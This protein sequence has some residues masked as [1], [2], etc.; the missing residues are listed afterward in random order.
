MGMSILT[1]EDNTEAVIVNDSVL[2]P[3]PLDFVFYCPDG[4]A[5]D[6]VLEFI[7]WVKPEDPRHVSEDRLKKLWAEFTE[8]DETQLDDDLCEV[9]Q[10]FEKYP[11]MEICETCKNQAHA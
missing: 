11:G 6:K 5:L 2:P 4:E 10:L 9:C 1:N 8:N 7:D 3:H